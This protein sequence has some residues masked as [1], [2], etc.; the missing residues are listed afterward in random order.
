MWCDYKAFHHPKFSNNFIL[1]NWVISSSI[2]PLTEKVDPK[3][4]NPVISIKSSSFIIVLRGLCPFV[5]VNKHHC[6]FLTHIIQTFY[7]SH[8]LTPSQ[9]GTLTCLVFPL[10]LL[11]EHY[12]P[13]KTG[14]LHMDTPLTS[15][16]LH[17]SVALHNSYLTLSQL[18]LCRY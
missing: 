3:H 11:P 2:L 8:Y 12:H 18:H 10:R 13:Q 9:T 1:T 6:L 17:R 15:I 14:L 5:E 4:L 16:I 7:I